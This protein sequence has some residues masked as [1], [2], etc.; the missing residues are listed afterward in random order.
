MAANTKLTV[1]FDSSGNVAGAFHPC[2]Y[3]PA[4]KTDE[5]TVD[6]GF[7]PIGGQQVRE[8]EVPAEFS[9]LEGDTL[10]QK[11]TQ[12]DAV[13]ATIRSIPTAGHAVTAPASML[14]SAI[15]T[16]AELA[17]GHATP[18]RL[19]V[20]SSPPVDVARSLPTAGQA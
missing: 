1:I 6:V 19:D 11:L 7:E 20:P 8:I 14:G 5:R 9:T 2:S 17:A 10:I 3:S 13:K 15:G 16:S 12:L 18:V 4:S